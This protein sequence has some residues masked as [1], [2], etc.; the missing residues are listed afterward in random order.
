MNVLSSIY[1]C[2]VCELLIAG[3]VSLSMGEVI[4]VVFRWKGDWNCDRRT[5]L[6]YKSV[7]LTNA[8]FVNGGSEQREDLVT[9]SD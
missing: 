1:D 8:A 9:F 7:T 6:S 3:E 5:V 2:I 4:L